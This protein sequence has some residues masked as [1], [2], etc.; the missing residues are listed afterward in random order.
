MWVSNFCCYCK[1]TSSLTDD[2]S[3]CDDTFQWLYCPICLRSLWANIYCYCWVTVH[4]CWWSRLKHWLDIFNTAFHQR[5]PWRHW[6]HIMYHLQNFPF[7]ICWTFT[8]RSYLPPFGN[9]FYNSILWSQ[10]MVYFN[11]VH[12]HF[13]GLILRYGH[14]SNVPWQCRHCTA[15]QQRTLVL[16]QM[17]THMTM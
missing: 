2:T 11:K 12:Y 5:F 9:I 6:S 8:Y 3:Y 16:W 15:Y 14:A 7:H 4:L 13:L 1:S 10:A 17:L